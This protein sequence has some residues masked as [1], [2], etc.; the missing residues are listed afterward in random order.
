MEKYTIQFYFVIIPQKQFSC[1]FVLKTG[2]H[3]IFPNFFKKTC[4]LCNNK[5]TLPHQTL[6]YFQCACYQLSSLGY[7]VLAV[8]DAFQVEHTSRIDPDLQI[9]PGIPEIPWGTQRSLGEPG[10]P[11]GNPEIPQGTWRSLRD[12]PALETRRKSS[13]I[14]QYN[15]LDRSKV[16]Q[17]HFEY[18]QV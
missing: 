10:D 5:A 17:G 2:C 1:S 18:C 11:S 4:L 8:N 7:S 9:D 16:V 14:P 15:T 6:N 12:P 13:E 3:K